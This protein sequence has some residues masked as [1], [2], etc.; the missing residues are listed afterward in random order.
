MPNLIQLTQGSQKV[1]PIA[2]IRYTDG[3]NVVESLRIVRY[4]GTK[5]A[6]VNSTVRASG[7]GSDQELAERAYSTQIALYGID[8]N[9]PDFS[10]KAACRCS[11]PSYRF[12]ADHANRSAG[13]AYGAR[14]A[15]YVRKTP[16]DDKRYPPKNPSNT[17]MLCKHL[18]L[19]THT[20]TQM[21]FFDSGV[22]KVQP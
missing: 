19:L 16:P 18:L 4:I 7:I 8:P 17:P 10:A 9:K 11:C 12:Y 5:M 2:V 13:A 15:P 21:G 20:I 1:L 14:F 3:R 6:V 22:Q